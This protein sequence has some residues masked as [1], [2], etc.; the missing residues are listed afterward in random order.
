MTDDDNN[1]VRPAPEPWGMPLSSMTY[2]IAT[3]R[4]QFAM[5]ALSGIALRDG[6]S[7]ADYMARFAYQIADFMMEA[8]K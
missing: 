2:E 5:A 7:S 3:L 8:R 6:L 4:D 1:F